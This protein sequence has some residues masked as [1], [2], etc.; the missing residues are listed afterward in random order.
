MNQMTAFEKEAVRVALVDMFRADKYFNIC[1]VDTC[2]RLAGVTVPKRTH[3]ALQAM[4][5]VSW[6]AMTPEMRKATAETVLALFDEPTLTL[7]TLS[8]SFLPN[9]EQPP[10]RGIFARL[11]GQGQPS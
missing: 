2:C 3:D 11:L 10:V 4:H 9:A 7:P 5:C 1:T 8:D 6:S